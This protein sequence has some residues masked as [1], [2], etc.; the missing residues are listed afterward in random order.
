MPNKSFEHQLASSPSVKETNVISGTEILFLKINKVKWQI[1]S[2]ITIFQLLQEME[3]S[4]TISKNKQ[5]K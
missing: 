4:I 2:S 3:S 5:A 1:R